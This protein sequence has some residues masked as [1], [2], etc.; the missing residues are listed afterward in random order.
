M[1]NL[2]RSLA[3][4]LA[5]RAVIDERVAALRGALQ[6]YELAQQEAAKQESEVESGAEGF[7]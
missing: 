6:G 1:E 2:K 7:F 5:Q 3:D 4:A